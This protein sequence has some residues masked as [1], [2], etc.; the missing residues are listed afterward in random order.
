LRVSAL[1]YF[2]ARGYSGCRQM[3]SLNFN[4]E[5]LLKRKK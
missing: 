2:N 5:E 1:F 4:L 3:V